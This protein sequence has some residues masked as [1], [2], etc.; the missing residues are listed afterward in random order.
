M[1]LN[2]EKL[3]WH[4]EDFG[5]NVQKFRIE[6]NHSNRSLHVIVELLEI[7]QDSI[8]CAEKIR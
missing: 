2:P 5:S 1:S 4:G 7:C 8:Q 3:D 6:A